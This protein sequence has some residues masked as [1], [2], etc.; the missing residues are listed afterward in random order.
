MC[1]IS[2]IYN[3]KLPTEF[4]LTSNRDEAPGRKTMPPEVH[5]M[6]DRQ[7]LFPK[8]SVAGGTWIGISDRKRLLC[9]MNGGFKSHE[10]KPPY[11]LSRGIVVLDL[12]AAED[13]LKEVKAYNLEGIEP[14]TLVTC[15]W[16]KK[17]AFYEVV[18]D[19]SKKYLKNLPLKNYIWSSS[20]LYSSEMKSLRERW[21]E[22]LEKEGSL[23]PEKLWNFHHSAGTGNKEIDLVMDRGHVMTKSITQVIKTSE[24]IKMKYEDLQKQNISEAIFDQVYD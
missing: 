7:L 23:N 2:L 9:I 11:R 5:K 10:S 17:L 4:Y 6:N 15:D 21:F 22:K 8:D 14:F 13:F 20:P 1:T 12:L 24:E 19:G 16:S 3:E 18:W